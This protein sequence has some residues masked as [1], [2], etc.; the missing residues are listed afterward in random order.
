[1]EEEIDNIQN[2]S[3]FQN[4]SPI[5]FQASILDSS[6]VSLPP[7]VSPSCSS[8]SSIIRNSG[9]I[10][11]KSEK[12]FNNDPIETTFMGANT[13][14]FCNERFKK[15]K[16][17]HFLHNILEMKFQDKTTDSA[18]IFI[19]PSSTKD[20]TENKKEN[21]PNKKTLSEVFISE[22]EIKIKPNILFSS[23]NNFDRYGLASTFSSKSQLH[24]ECVVCND[25]SSGKHYGEYT[26]EGCKS[27]FK[28]SVRRNLVYQC[29]STKNCSIDQQVSNFFK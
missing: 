8:P 2:D 16:S 20:D 25:K 11:I 6:N 23:L 12:G 1:M 22:P 10:E 7:S 24:I 29:R 27:F 5:T 4:E 9:M 3:S 14:N 26:C 21:F 17:S 15:F 18:E 19:G 28:R 13:F